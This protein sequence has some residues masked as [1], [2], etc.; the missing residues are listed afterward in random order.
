MGHKVKIKGAVSLL[1]RR[2]A[3]P[4]W[5]RRRWLDKTQHLSTDQIEHIQLKLLKRLIKHCYKYVP[6]YRQ[7]MDSKRIS[8]LNFRSLDDIKRLPI[9]TKQDV[10]RAGTRLISTK[11]PMWTL[12]K[13]TTGGTTGK[14]LPVYRDVFSIGNEHAFVRRQFDW[15]GIGL[16]DRCAYLTWRNVVSPG[17]TVTKPYAYDPVMKELI[18]STFHLSADTALTYVAAMSEYD[19]KALVAYPS[20]AYVMA[21][22]CIDR[23][24]KLPLKAVLTSSEVLDDHRRQIIESAFECPVYDYYGSAER[25]CYIHTCEHHSYHILPEYGLTEL[26][27]AESQDADEYRI[28]ATGFWNMSMPFI[29]YDTGDNVI[30]ESIDCPCKRDFPTVK[31]II[32]RQSNSITTSTGRTIGATAMT[33]LFKNVLSGI[34]GVGILESRIVLQDNDRITLEHVSLDRLSE[35]QDQQLRSILEKQ[36]PPELSVE[37]KQVKRIDRTKNG[38]SL[39]IVSSS[40]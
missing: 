15:A 11:Y 39:S 13:A 26:H 21:Q 38:K 9:L 23:N 33:R 18:L 14:P 24:I 7:I 25:T 32:G 19:I 16:S 22:V 28:I 40:N 3:G 27:T 2:Y 34:K 6:Y 17:K 35:K 12:H 30:T 36:L 31:R 1:T 20:A 10:I 29:R 5:M 8:P 37:I 4:F